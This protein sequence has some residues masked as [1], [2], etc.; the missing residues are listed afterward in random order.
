MSR[1]QTRPGST[2]TEALSYLRLSKF[3]N[4]FSQFMTMTDKDHS[5]VREFDRVTTE[6][7]AMDS[8][9]NLLFSIARFK[10]YTSHYPSY[11]THAPPSFPPFPPLS[12]RFFLLDI[13]LSNPTDMIVTVIGY[14]MKSSRFT[15][16]HRKALRWPI[17]AF[18]YIGIDNDNG[19]AGAGVGGNE[20]QT[21][22]MK[23][24]EGENLN[25][26]KPFEK[27]LYGCHDFLKEKR[28]TRNPY[29]RFHGYH[30]SGKSASPT[31]LSL[32][33]TLLRRPRETQ[34]LELIRFLS[35]FFLF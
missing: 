25:G 29:R 19:R 2:L 27:D 10:E 4:V 6:D 21:L 7:Y 12:V 33:D 35:L 22:M 17:T 28:K 1:G 20:T 24:Y 16:L 14:G 3:G 9:Q 18:N 11:S 30:S 23:D 26:F 8:F 13:S 32:S 31:S 34:T 15:S 5:I